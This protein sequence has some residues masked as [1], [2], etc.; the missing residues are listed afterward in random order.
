[1]DK[2]VL[3]ANSS[4]LKDFTKTC[5]YYK[6]CT[7]K[8]VEKTSTACKSHFKIEGKHK[9]KCKANKKTYRK[10]GQVPSRC[11]SDGR[12]HQYCKC[13]RHC[14]HIMDE[15]NITIN[16]CKGITCHEQEERSCKSKK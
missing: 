16:W 13:H 12:G 3:N 9:T 15:H 14:N 6:E 4:A 1:M 7:P 2:E 10:W 8:M 11:H 5:V